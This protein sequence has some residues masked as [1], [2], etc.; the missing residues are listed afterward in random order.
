VPVLKALTDG[1]VNC[2]TRDVKLFSLILSCSVEMWHIC[3][4]LNLYVDQKLN[5]I[6]EWF[7]D[8]V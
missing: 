7:I 4:T 3:A 2:L 1:W 6:N 5:K 8:L